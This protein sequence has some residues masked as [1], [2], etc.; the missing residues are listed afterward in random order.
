LSVIATGKRDTAEA[1]LLDLDGVLRI[2]DPSAA[3]VAE[4]RHG[5]P[6]GA[7]ASAA[8]N[9]PRLRPAIVGEYSHD[10]WM[11]ATIGDLA[12]V[13]G[14]ADRAAAAVAAWHAYR[15]EVV[16]SVLDFVRSI[17]IEG[18]P[19]GIAT[20]AT[21]LLDADLE[22]LGLREEVDVVVNS[23]VIGAHKPTQKFFAEACVAVGRPPARVLFVD[24]EDRNVRG[25]RVAGLAAY[26]W[27]GPSDLS[28]LRAALGH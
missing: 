20:N 2:F 11:S 1:L 27:T 26:R 23:S 4:Q 22:S 25:A 12:E 17:R 8:L 3:A 6:E 14:S 16:P 24:D 13:I 21:S 5:V 19:V 10:E 28:Y 18:V 9:W 7:L 15:G